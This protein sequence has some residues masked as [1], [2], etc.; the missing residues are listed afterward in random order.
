MNVAIHPS[1]VG[2]LTLVSAD[3]QL[4]GCYFA[5]TEFAQ[6]QRAKQRN[7][8]SATD[9][10]LTLAR[11]ELNEYFAG[12]LT[13]FSV[14]IALH[15]TDFQC[16]VWRALRSIPFGETA[17]YGEIAKRLGRPK[18]VRAVGGANG[19]NPICIFVP[20]HRVIGASGALTGFGGGLERKRYLLALERAR[21]A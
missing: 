3:G 18:A 14:P 1:P 21:S 20:C 11:R 4:I 8:P 13:K 15:G 12:S 10:V 6:Q 19:Q 2:P 17:S 9:A 7:A 16:Q 5:N